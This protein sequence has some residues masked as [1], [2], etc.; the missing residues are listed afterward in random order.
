MNEESSVT[1]PQKTN[2]LPSYPLNA[3]LKNALKEYL[4][5][6]SYNE[7]SELVAGLELEQ[8]P[9][10]VIIDISNMLQK[11]RPMRLLQGLQMNIQSVNKTRQQ[12]GE[13]NGKAV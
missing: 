7:V 11:E 1:I 4:G 6:R 8:V 5:E 13:Q 9:G 3:N 10:Q 12:Q 2:N